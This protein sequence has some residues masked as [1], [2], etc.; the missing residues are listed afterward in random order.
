MPNALRERVA[1]GYNTRA[2]WLE[3]GSPML[4]EAAVYAGF[5]FIL[6]D[7]EHC[8]ASIETTTHLVRAVTAAG[9]HPM[10]R[11]AANDEAHLKSV[12]DAGITSIL[13]PRVE[14]AEEAEAAVKFARYPP[15]GVRGFAGEVRA[16]RYGLDPGYATRPD[17][18][19]LMLQIESKLG[20]DNAEAI[21][22]V[23]GVDM[24]FPGPYDLSG[25][26]G[27]RGET[28]H[29]A[30][31]AAIERIKE[32]ARRN[33]RPLGTVPHGSFDVASLMDAGFALVIFNSDIGHAISGLKAD[34][35]ATP[36]DWL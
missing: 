34:A 33:G 36:K 17:D 2:L 19:F 20:V 7:N 6:I 23:P 10:V 25:S 29:P 8:G 14:T 27:H 1:G 24:I 31:L 30:N 22:A 21:A 4:A 32:A 28:G 15:L 35:Q 3:T 16:A 26:L 9:G 5:R 12:L 18:I 11:V 13:V